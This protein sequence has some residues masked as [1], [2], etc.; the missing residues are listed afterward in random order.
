MLIFSIDNGNGPVDYSNYVAENSISIVDSINVPTLLTLTLENVDGTFVIPKQSGYCTLYSTKFDRFLFTGFVTNETGKSYL[1]LS[2]RTPNT[3]FQS[4]EF[5]L[6]AT[7]DEWLLNVKS[8][9]FLPAY[10]NQTMGQILTNLANILAPGFYD[11][12]LMQPGDIVPYFNYDPTQKWS[13]LAKEF[14]DQAMMRYKVLNRQIQFIPYG[15][16]PLGLSYDDTL[17]DGTFDPAALQTQVLTVPPV[18]DAIVVGEVEAATMWDDYFI[19][20]GFTT[21]F[22]LR[23][24][25]FEGGTNLLL[26]DDWTETSFS[27]SWTIQ[28]PQ[29]M[30]TLAGGLNAFGVTGNVLG[31]SYVLL[32]NGL[33]LGGHLSLQHGYF[34][35]TDVNTGLIGAVFGG[36]PFDFSVTG[37]PLIAFQPLVASGDTFIPSPSGAT[38]LSLQG[39]VFGAVATPILVKTQINHQYLLVTRIDARRYT[40]YNQIYR[41]FDSVLGNVDLPS[42]AD[43]TFQISDYNQGLPWNPPVVTTYTVHGVPLPSFGQYVLL[44]PITINLALNYT[45][46]SVQP[47]ALLHV[48]GLFGP[49]G[50]SLPVLPA[51]LGPDTYYQLGFGMS[52]ATATIQTGQQSGSSSGGAGGLGNSDQLAFYSGYI[53]YT[54]DIPG[55]GARI[56]LTSWESAYSL[57]RVQDPIQV[58]AQAV[59]TGDDGLRTAIFKDLKPSPRTSEECEWAGVAQIADKSSVQYQ[60]TYTVFDFFWNNAQDYPWTGRFLTINSPTR[61]ILNQQLLVQSVTT[62]VIEM[63]GETIQFAVSFGQDLFLE[64]LL[65]R[66]IATPTNTLEPNDTAT[67]P[68]LQFINDVGLTYLPDLIN[69][70]ITNITG[71]SATFDLGSIPITGCE[72]RS[73]DWG[74]GVTKTNLIA[75]ETTQQF[76]LTR[77]ARDQTWYMRQVLN[78]QTSRFTRAMRV[79]YPLIPTAPILSAVDET[80]PTHPIVELG[81]SGDINNIRGVEIRDFDNLT[82]LEQTTV[83]SPADL[84]FTYNNQFGLTTIVLYAYFFN[85]QWEY[86]PPLVITFNIGNPLVGIEQAGPNIL[87]NPGFESVTL[88]YANPQVP[89]NGRFIADT[90]G[91]AVSGAAQYEI[92]LGSAARTGSRCGEELFG[93]ASLVNGATA[94]GFIGTPFPT[95]PTKCFPCRGGDTYYFGGYAK[96][97]TNAIPL[98]G[99]TGTVGFQVWFYD[100]NGNFIIAAASQA[101]LSASTAYVFLDGTTQVPTQAS[102]MQFVCLSTLTNNTG[103]TIAASTVQPLQVGLFDDCFLFIANRTT[104]SSYRPLSNPLTSF[105]DPGTPETAEIDIAS[106]IMRSGTTDVILNT[107]IISTLAL[108][109]LYYTYYD[110][111]AFVG[112]NQTYN[113]TTQKELALLGESRY[114]LGSIATPMS[115]AVVGTVGN[116]DG[117][118]GSQSGQGTILYCDIPATFP[119]WTSP[120]GS[121]PIF[122][123]ASGANIILLAGGVIN[124]LGNCLDPVATTPTS[125][126]INAALPGGNSNI[127]GFTAFGPP[128]ITQRYQSATLNFVAGVS[129]NTVN[130]PGA[131]GGAEATVVVFYGSSPTVYSLPFDVIAG[132]GLAAPALYT[133]P[134][135]A[136]ANPSLIFVNFGVN[137]GEFPH[138]S[139]TG[140]LELDVYGVWVEA[141]A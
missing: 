105:I 123:G 60:G 92:V 18:N 71:T 107:G 36:Q 110:D 130:V 56:G 13:D 26:Q 126:V 17:G 68:T 61:N 77:G 116:N 93:A 4:M 91:T 129:V 20:D 90:W 104:H 94:S 134:L 29:G 100:V 49:T 106:F 141:I 97:F 58:A 74:W 37:N 87:A 86:S 22:Q 69:A 67:Q 53:P 114:F 24:Q 2:Q 102:F 89:G 109:T 31:S 128:G 39:V 96:W 62:T 7:S 117:G 9:P 8:V 112:G 132:G 42:L 47:Q 139:S 72:I 38:N 43:V 98:S 75:T 64:K 15:D 33:E 83:L 40:R 65:R 81:F 70:K 28:D 52:L 88:A 118:S 122:T 23:H 55:V 50:S 63:F 41:S 111:P 136:G 30:F 14:G 119:P 48:A 99:V 84:N 115:G 16:A 1:G 80:D 46:I 82:V 124:N 137:S 32:N 131:G 138:K 3:N 113:A 66:F 101:L 103:S 95:N 34:T 25:V 19:G 125:L 133:V 45:L 76:S 59:I 78:G 79:L 11:T 6:Q 135:P 121:F 108:N 57:A 5:T 120:P 140:I 12:S 54:N 51:N 35:F 21:N 44:D 10:V 27:S 127:A 73:A 85:L